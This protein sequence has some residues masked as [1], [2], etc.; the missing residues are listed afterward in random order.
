MQQSSPKLIWAGTLCS[1]LGLGL[2]GCS[3]GPESGV[4]S[5]NSES[6]THSNLP[7]V[8]RM[9]QSRLTSGMP[10]PTKHHCFVTTQE[11]RMR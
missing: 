4:H 2:I 3:S 1:V 8:D 10:I 5:Q 9:P 11:S 7:L 6:G